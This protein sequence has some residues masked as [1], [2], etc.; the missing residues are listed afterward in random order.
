MLL[1]ST[2]A[3][4]RR[5]RS[6]RL[7]VAGLAAIALAATPL[8]TASA[9]AP[10]GQPPGAAQV[11][12]ASSSL[13]LPSW[14]K[15]TQVRGSREVWVLPAY[16]AGEQPWDERQ[17]LRV[18]DGDL[19]WFTQMSHGRFSMTATKVLPPLRFDSGHGS[20][21][22]AAARV[23]APALSRFYAEAPADVHLVA[24]TRSPDCPYS[25][26]GDTPGRTL[27]LAGYSTD[28]RI[29]RLTLLHEL[30]HNLGLPHSSSY[31]GAL[32]SSSA[33]PGRLGSD[34]VEYGSMADIMGGH[35]AAARLSAA[36]LAAL[37]WGDGV[38]LVPDATSS[39]FVID[40]PEVSKAGADAAIVDD[41]VSGMRYSFTYVD[42]TSSSAAGL[43]VAGRGVFLHHVPGHHV[44]PADYGRASLSLWMP[45][46]GRHPGTA[47]G[48]GAGPGTAW[49]SPT[50]AVGIRVLS[51]G[52]GVARIEISADPQ[53]RIVDST[54]PTWPVE[55]TIHA[56]AG[57]STATLRLPAAWDQSGIARYRVTAQG[58]RVL[59][60]RSPRALAVSG[61]VS[62]AVARPGALVQVTATDGAGNSTTWTQRVSTPR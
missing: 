21:C 9:D 54:G 25:A 49:V 47:V 57:S 41:P 40:L 37:G 43:P 32:L 34:I 11:H 23:L 4:P 44:S 45:W 62:L 52:G 2:H 26:I 56:A 29:S 33:A 51:L 3:N 24:L 30:G 6:L 14:A 10:P 31:S 55:P 46:E 61:S 7:I 5:E 48:I 15:T 27:I 19:G 35:G 28:S 13:L 36:S 18:I 1:R 8:A 39:T 17:L 58:A 59:S 16:D 38:L 12:E 20:S 42:A 50:G 60:V 22:D 53:G